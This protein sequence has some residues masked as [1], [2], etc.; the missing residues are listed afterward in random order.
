LRENIDRNFRDCDAI[1]I[2]LPHR[3]HQRCAFEQFIAR[4]RKYS[5]L[6]NRSVPVPGAPNPLPSHRN[7]SRR[8]NLANKID[9]ADIDPKFQ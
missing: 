1:Q 2:A 4:R 3:S 9:R 6:R 8:A 7:R 5:A